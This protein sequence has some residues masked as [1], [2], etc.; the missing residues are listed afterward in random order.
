M[1]R[2]DEGPR[3]LLER[4]LPAV[5]DHDLDALV[6]CFS[7]DYVNETPAHPLRGFGGRD[8]V[9]KNWAQIFAGVPDVHAEVPRAAADGDTLWTEWDMS[10][11][12]TDGGAFHMRGV[13]IFGVTDDRATSARF[14]LE[15]VEHATGDVDAATV[16]LVGSTKEAS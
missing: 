3:A 13:V 1:T 2:S 9:R 6:S 7:E 4:L 11:S 14:Y 15:P 16:R 12:R 5:N 8:Q 10:G